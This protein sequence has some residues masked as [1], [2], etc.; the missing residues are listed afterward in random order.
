VF[1]SRNGCATVPRA[2]F[3]HALKAAEI[4]D[5]R[6][7]D[8]RQTFASYLLMSGASLAELAETL[9]HRILAMVKRYARP[10]C[11]HALSVVD[12]M[13]ARLT[14]RGFG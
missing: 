4:E 14:D 13:D 9:G 7:H 11:S 5:F 3:D 6:F 10:S 8:L 1:V 2:A 12:R